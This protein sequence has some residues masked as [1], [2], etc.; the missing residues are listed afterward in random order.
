MALSDV[1]MR[2]VSFLRA[3]YPEGIPAR[4][5]VPLLALLR[6]RLSD[7]DVIA[8]AAAVIS[9]NNRPVDVT[10]V[11]VAITKL[12]DEMPSPEDTERVKRRLAAVGWPVDDAAGR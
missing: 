5:Y 7:D 12:T 1:V 8:V 9:R 10:D 11:R 4:D 2:V 6:R 3:G